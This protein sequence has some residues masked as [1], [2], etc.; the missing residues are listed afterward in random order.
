[1]DAPGAANPNLDRFRFAHVRRPIWPLDRDAEWRESR[2][3]R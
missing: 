3:A 1:V 2:A